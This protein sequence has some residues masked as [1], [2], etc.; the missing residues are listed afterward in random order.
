MKKL[1]SFLLTICLLAGAG[2]SGNASAQEPEI[3][4]QEMTMYVADVE[5]TIP[6]SIYHIGDSD[7]PYV[8]LDE[9]AEIMTDIKGSDDSDDSDASDTSDDSDASDATVDAAPA[10]ETDAGEDYVLS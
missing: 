4:S 9:W 2:V 1:L 8:S 6:I 5:T 7:V 3:S 10:A